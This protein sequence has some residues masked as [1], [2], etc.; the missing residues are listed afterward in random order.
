MGKVYYTAIGEN[1]NNC[2]SCVFNGFKYICCNHEELL[3]A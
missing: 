3:Y 2:I 1:N